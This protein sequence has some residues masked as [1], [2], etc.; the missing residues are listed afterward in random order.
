MT[1]TCTCHQTIISCCLT[2]FVSRFKFRDEAEET[3]EYNREQ[4]LGHTSHGADFSLEFNGL[5]LDEDGDVIVHRPQR[6]Q[7]EVIE[8]G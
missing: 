7:Y 2:A 8:I 6:V 1:T 4:L 5:E 3:V